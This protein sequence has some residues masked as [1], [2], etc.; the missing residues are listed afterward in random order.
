MPTI[1]NIAQHI[2]PLALGTVKET[3][4]TYN[5]TPGYMRNMGVS[6]G[7]Q[8]GTLAYTPATTSASN[9]TYTQTNAAGP[10]GIVC[11][12][13]GAYIDNVNIDVTTAFNAGTNNTITVALSPTSGTAGTT[14]MTVTGTGVTI[15]VGRYTLGITISSAAVTQQNTAY[16]V[17]VSNGQAS[18]TDQILMAWY[19]QTGTAATTGAC[20]IGIDYCIR[21]PDGSWYQQSPTY[22]IATIPVTTY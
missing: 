19:T 15:G 1:G 5:T 2:G 12:P 8:F 10:T 13:A 20:T 21:N 22:P 4:A 14:I 6:D 7:Y 9:L 16:W 3:N 17:N 11:I 18:P